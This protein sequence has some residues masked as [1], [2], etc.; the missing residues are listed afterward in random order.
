MRLNMRNF[1]IF[2]LREKNNYLHCEK[3]GKLFNRTDWQVAKTTKL[4]S[5]VPAEHLRWSCT[6]VC[7]TA[8]FSVVTQR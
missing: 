8:V 6:L 1:H 2:E 3:K 4:Q 5:R 7:Y